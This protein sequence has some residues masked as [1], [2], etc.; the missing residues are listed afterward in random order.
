MK[1]NATLNEGY[2]VEMDVGGYDYILDQSK[3]KGGTEQG[4]NPSALLMSS[5]LGC[6]AMVA[7]GFLEARKVDFDTIESSIDFEVSGSNM[8]PT[9]EASVYVK[10]IG[11]DMD[12]K[13]KQQIQQIVETGCPV[14]N[15]MDPEKSTIETKVEVA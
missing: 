14:A 9:A 7:K 2:R 1:I 4:T 8:R 6:K 12:D 10:V 15:L 13:L 3:E 11:A 5:I